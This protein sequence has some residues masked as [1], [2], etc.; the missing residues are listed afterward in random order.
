MPRTKLVK[1]KEG[2]S[3]HEVDPEPVS[4]LSPDERRDA[5]VV[6][7]EMVD[8]IDDYKNDE[9]QGTLAISP[10]KNSGGGIGRAEKGGDFNEALGKI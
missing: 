10:S 6:E 8:S 2:A 7:A 9:E 5:E 3:K 4:Q 1:K